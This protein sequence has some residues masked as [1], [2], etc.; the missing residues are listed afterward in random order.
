MCMQ[1]VV[2]SIILLRHNYVNKY[3]HK[4]VLTVLIFIV[5]LQLIPIARL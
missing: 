5:L 3:V 1:R 4:V 2:S